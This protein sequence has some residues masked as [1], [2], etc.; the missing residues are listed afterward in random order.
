MAK[1]NEVDEEFTKIKGFMVFVGLP[2]LIFMMSGFLITGVRAN[3]TITNFWP[4]LGK[5]ALAEALVLSI[6]WI[7]T[8]KSEIG[9]KEGIMLF[10]KATLY[11]ALCNILWVILCA[12]SA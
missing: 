9:F 1:K 8:L 4:L 12:L 11:V 6:S 5:F 2:A 3:P 10:L 7:W